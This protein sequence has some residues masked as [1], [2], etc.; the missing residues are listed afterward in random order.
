[1]YC[2]LTDLFSHSWKIP[3]SSLSF[4]DP[5]RT[6]HQQFQQPQRRSSDGQAAESA[7]LKKNIKCDSTRELLY[8][9]FSTWNNFILV[10]M[11]WAASSCVHLT[12]IAPYFFL[13]NPIIASPRLVWLF[14]DGESRTNCAIEL[15]ELDDVIYIRSKL[16]P[17]PRSVSLW[18]SVYR[19]R[20]IFKRTI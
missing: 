20:T 11:T 17:I 14:V 18:Q 15:N 2:H 3:M 7:H 6:F 12:V 10:M 1:M 9:L 19:L 13:P 16:K 4:F 8:V 5:S